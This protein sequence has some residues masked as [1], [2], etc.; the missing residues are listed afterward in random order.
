[1]YNNVAPTDM[2]RTTYNV[3]SHFPKINPP[4]KE[5]GMPK[6]AANTHNI[7][8]M[9]NTHEIKIRLVFFKLKK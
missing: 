6:P 2:P 1:M 9:K 5:T 7:V 3:P 8:P 4:N